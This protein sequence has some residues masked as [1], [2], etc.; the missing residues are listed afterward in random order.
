MPDD[1][2]FKL[3]KMRLKGVAEFLSPIVKAMALSA[4][5]G[6]IGY[7]NSKR[8]QKQAAE[9][10][11]QSMITAFKENPEFKKDTNL[12]KE[13]FKE[14][15]LVAPGIAGNPRMAAKVLASNMKSGFSVD[16]IHKLTMIQTYG[17]PL[18]D[19]SSLAAGRLAAS[20]A[21]DKILSIIGPKIYEDNISNA[22]AYLRW[23]DDAQ[24]LMANIRKEHNTYRH[25]K[26]S[27]ERN[28]HMERKISDECIGEMLGDR[29]VMA[30]T[31]GLFVSQ[32]A[33]GAR[34]L[35][36]AWR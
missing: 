29:Y 16:D 22:R 21:F 26:T 36:T 34:A 1:A 4:G 2:A 5:V 3:T 10:L 23:S 30:K 27:A 32:M 20:N 14:L 8:D 33:N 24:D 12:F 13:R 7:L 9:H 35:K 11:A 17:K 31:A 15:A 19:T 25:E 28:D 18:A 6:G